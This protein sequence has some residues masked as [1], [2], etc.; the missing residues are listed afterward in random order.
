MVTAHTDVY[1]SC[2]KDTKKSSLLTVIV[3]T[4]NCHINVLKGR[5]HVNV[6]VCVWSPG[7]VVPAPPWRAVT[8]VRPDASASI[9]TGRWTHSCGWTHTHTEINT[10]HQYC[11]HITMRSPPSCR[12]GDGD[13]GGIPHAAVVTSPVLRVHAAGE[14]G[15]VNTSR[16][17]RCDSASPSTRWDTRTGRGPRSGP[18]SGMA[19]CRWLLTSRDRCLLKDAC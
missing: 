17:H 4:G 7:A 2:V 14:H 6:C 5:L 8:S 11:K 16:T 10:C 18:R 15:N 9:L 19:G 13:A 1:S 12:Q 3:N